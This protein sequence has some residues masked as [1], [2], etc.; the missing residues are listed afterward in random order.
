MRI[1]AILTCYNRREN[2]LICLKALYSSDMPPDWELTVYLTNDG[3]TDGTSE[4][5]R[6][7]FPEVVVTQSDG[8]AYW[9]GG[10]HLSFEKAL[11]N[12]HDRFLWINDDTHLFKH[13][14]LRL[15]QTLQMKTAGSGEHAIVVGTIQN[16]EMTHATYG[17]VIFPS[18]WK[19]TTPQLVYSETEAVTCETINGNCVWIPMSV[20]S[21][22]GNLDPIFVHG[23][24]DFDYGF[25]ARKAG[26]AL[27]VAPGFAGTCDRNG[28]E[29]TFLDNRLSLRKRLRIVFGPKGR[30]PY[31]WAVF[32]RR[33]CGP[34]WILYWFF[35]YTR[36]IV[37][38]GI[39]RLSGIFSRR[40]VT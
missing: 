40:R 24:G 20:A 8:N 31:A 23:L 37:T 32:T 26:M 1:A 27:W 33:H 5:V 2:T 16:R 3:S 7:L 25:R 11:R 22:T 4:I 19:R 12:N 14:L 15:E 29:G 9:N 35:P 34:A 36:V 30:P 28:V 21:A 18:W 17:G 39:T 10:M 38:W 6:E 13:T